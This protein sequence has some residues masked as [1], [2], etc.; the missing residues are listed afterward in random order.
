M[1][2]ETR[3]YIGRLDS[4]AQDEMDYDFAPPIK[5]G[6]L[7]RC[8]S[9]YAMIDMCKIGHLESLSNSGILKDNEHAFLYASDGDTHIT[10]DSYGDPLKV[11]RIEDVINELKEL[12]D[13]SEYRRYEWA[14]V[15]MQTMVETSGEELF[16]LSEGH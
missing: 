4:R 13:N 7:E 15:L 5:T 6:K 9:N 10:E 3:L 12:V 11:A 8:F 14:L 2:Y 1:G 16:V